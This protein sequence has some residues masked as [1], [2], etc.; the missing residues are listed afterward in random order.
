[1]AIVAIYAIVDPGHLRKRLD[2]SL[3]SQFC[4]KSY[5]GT[6]IGNKLGLIVFIVKFFNSVILDI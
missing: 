4:L 2:C 6:K 5:F 3:W 1:M